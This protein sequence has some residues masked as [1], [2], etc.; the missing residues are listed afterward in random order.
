LVPTPARLKLLQLCDEWHSSRVST[1][2]PVHTVNRIQTLKV[3]LPSL[4]LVLTSL[5][6]SHNTEGLD[7]LQVRCT[8]HEL[9]HHADDVTQPLQV[10]I[11]YRLTGSYYGACI[12]CVRLPLLRCVHR[13]R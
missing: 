13:L 6:T 12:T 10:S 11:D 1:F 8:N 5:T 2:V 9:C 4:G 7:R 3:A